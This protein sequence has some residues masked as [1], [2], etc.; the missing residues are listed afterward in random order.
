LRAK[1]H[2]EN[3]A[4]DECGYGDGCYLDLS[5]GMKISHAEEGGEKRVEWTRVIVEVV[6]AGCGA[7]GEF[8]L[9]SFVAFKIQHEESVKYEYDPLVGAEAA[10]EGFIS[11]LEKRLARFSHE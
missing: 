4:E 9:K 11:I 10:L 1:I 8:F 6:D 5:L 7:G 2:E 3:N